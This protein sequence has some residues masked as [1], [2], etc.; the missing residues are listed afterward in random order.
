MKKVFIFLLCLTLP[1]LADPFSKLNRMTNNSVKQEQR[2]V[3]SD[4]LTKN[5]CQRIQ[6]VLWTD[7]DITNLKIVGVLRQQ[8][9]WHAFITDDRQVFLLKEGD[10]LGKQ[11]HKIEKINKKQLI[12]RPQ[13]ATSCEFGEPID[14]LF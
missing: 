5:S 13:S 10:L 4:A 2:S 6:S 14:W 12:L 3:M 9:L 1:V 8:D 11:P 7:V